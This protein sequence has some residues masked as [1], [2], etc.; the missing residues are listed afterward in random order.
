M[1]ILSISPRKYFCLSL[2][3]SLLF[4]DLIRFILLMYCFF[5]LK[6]AIRLQYLIPFD[7][8]N[9]LPRDLDDKR[10][11]WYDKIQFWRAEMCTITTIM[12]FPLKQCISIY[13]SSFQMESKFDI[14]NL[15]I[16][17][18]HISHVFDS[19]VDIMHLSYCLNKMVQAVFS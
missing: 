19:D 11:A 15:R 4:C 17:I 8:A 13:T 9:Y 1:N 12:L 7:N 3:Y 16:N 6:I 18:K 14:I 5:L 2:G 10:R